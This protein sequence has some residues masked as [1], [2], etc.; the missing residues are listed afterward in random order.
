M[1]GTFRVTLHKKADF[2]SQPFADLA[3][4]PLIETETDWV[5][6]DFSHP[7]YLAEFGAKGESEVTRSLPQFRHER[8]FPENAPLSDDDQKPQ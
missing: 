6:M 8:R 2:A 7:N 1:T 5:L 3:M 4:D